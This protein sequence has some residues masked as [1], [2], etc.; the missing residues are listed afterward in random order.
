MYDYK[1]LGFVNT[2]AMFEKAYAGAYAV[3]AFNFISIEQINAIFD[4]CISKNS[5]VILLTSPNLLRQ[6]GFEVIARISQAGV[7]RVR[8]AGSCLP[9]ALHLDHGMSYEDCVSAIENG[10]SSVMIDGS[11]LS[12]D[13]NISL[14]RKVVEYARERDITVEGELGILSGTE[15]EGERG[16]AT[17]QYTD[18]ILVEEF[19]QRSGVDSLAVSIGTC[20]GLVKLKPNPD[21]TL[22]ELRYDILADIQRRLPGFPIVLHGASTI[23]SEYVDMINAY[24]GNLE[25]AV[26]IPEEQVAKAA[27]MAVCKINIASDGWIAAL[28]FTRKIL[29]ENPAAIDSRVFTRKIRPHLAKLYERKIDVMGSAGMGGA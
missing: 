5:P 13:E 11:A 17:S 26:G 1:E 28:A 9:V 10:Y 16:N 6:I 25:R 19:V 4:A 15:E 8:N 29:A 2:R 3:P 23:K 14:S 24:G 12:F 18:P 7:D 22:P 27:K 20:H 21:R